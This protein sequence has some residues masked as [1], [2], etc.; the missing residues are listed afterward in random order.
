MIPNPICFLLVSSHPIVNFEMFPTAFRKNILQKTTLWTWRS[1]PQAAV[2]CSPTTSPRARRIWASPIRLRRTRRCFLQRSWIRYNGVSWWSVHDELQAPFGIG[3][4]GYCPVFLW[5]GVG[6][7]RE[8]TLTCFFRKMILFQKAFGFSF[9]LLTNCFQ[10]FNPQVLRAGCVG[11]RAMGFL[12]GI[13]LFGGGVVGW[14]RLVWEKILENPVHKIRG[15][16]ISIDSEVVLFYTNSFLPD[17]FCLS[18]L[19]CQHSWK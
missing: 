7:E 17:A 4:C 12:V 2:A 3:M 10:S 13:S 6:M 9:S 16:Q 18:P 15:S 8:E 11:F 5:M 19:R 1:L 14:G